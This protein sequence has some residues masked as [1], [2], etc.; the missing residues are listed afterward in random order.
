MGH[1][2]HSL[3]DAQYKGRTAVTLKLFG[4]ME[5]TGLVI[6]VTVHAS[7][8]QEQMLATYPAIETG[9][10]TPL[11]KIVVLTHEQIPLGVE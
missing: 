2:A 8:K 6:T 4:V 3:S 1:F 5:T 10:A 11:I 7:C 9:I